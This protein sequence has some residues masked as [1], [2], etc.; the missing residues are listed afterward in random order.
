MTR[1]GETVYVE[2][3]GHQN[4]LVEEVFLGLG[5]KWGV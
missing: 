2:E 4:S 3:I 5:T 1:G